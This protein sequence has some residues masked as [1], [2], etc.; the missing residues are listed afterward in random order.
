[1]A[2]AGAVGPV[3]LPDLSAG[4]DLSEDEAREAAR[5]LLAAGE[6]VALDGRGP[7]ESAL[8]ITSDALADLTARAAEALG[9]HHRRFPLRRGMPREEL[10]GRLGLEGRAFEGAL[11][12]WASRG[13]VVEAGGAVALAGHE[14]RPDAGQAERAREL[15]AALRA[16]PFSPP[17]PEADDDLLAY[18]EGRGE[19]VRADGAVA[20]AAEAY[21]EMVQRV[22]ERLEERGTVTLAEVRDLLGTSRKYAQALLERMDSDGITRRTG[23]ERALRRAVR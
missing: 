11:A 9:E 10:R 3:A 22:T 13:E 4:L 21:R 6:L 8:L 16:S 7:E 14:P 1:M 2:V 17:A 5:E 15:L 18:L 20:F 12:L 19:V 23:D